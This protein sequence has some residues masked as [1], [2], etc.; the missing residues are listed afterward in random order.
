MLKLHRGIMQGIIC[1]LGD[2]PGLLLRI[3]YFLNVISNRNCIEKYLSLS[4]LA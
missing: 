3:F 4:L 2:E 1:D